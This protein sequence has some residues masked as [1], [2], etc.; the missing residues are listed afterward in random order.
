MIVH[1]NRRNGNL[2]ITQYQLADREKQK[3][4][5]IKVTGNGRPHLKTTLILSDCGSHTRIWR[6]TKISRTEQTR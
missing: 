6:K 2:A 4:K 5:E 3:N 1:M